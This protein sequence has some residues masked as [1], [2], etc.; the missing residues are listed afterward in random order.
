MRSFCSKSSFSNFSIR[1]VCSSSWTASFL[2]Y[3]CFSSTEIYFITSAKEKPNKDFLKYV[4]SPHCFGD[5]RILC[6]IGDVVKHKHLRN[7]VFFNI[8]RYRILKEAQ[9]DQMGFGVVIDHKLR[10]AVGVG[11]FQNQQLAFAVAGNNG[12]RLV[13]IQKSGILVFSFQIFELVNTVCYI[14]SAVVAYGMRQSF[15]IGCDD[16]CCGEGIIDLIVRRIAPCCARRKAAR[17]SF[18]ATASRQHSSSMLRG[19]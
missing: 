4:F 19:L 5:S 8:V 7:A 14:V 6:K 12:C 11:I 10:K 9:V 18:P 3:S 17:P 1:T 2:S 13:G 16:I 15:I